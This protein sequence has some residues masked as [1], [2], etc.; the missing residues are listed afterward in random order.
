MLSQLREL[1]F[2]G[3]DAEPSLR[4]LE[5]IGTLH[6]NGATELPHD[7]DVPV[8]AAWR[9]LIN[10]DDRMRALGTASIDNHGAAQGTSLRLSL[11][12]PQPALS[13][14]AEPFLATVD[15]AFEGGPARVGGVARGRLHGY[16]YRRRAALVRNAA[17]PTDGLP[18]RTR[19]LIFGE[20]GAAQFA[21]MII[22]MD[23]RTGIS[24]ILLSRKACDANELVRATLR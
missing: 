20:I 3:R 17:L 24:E 13:G 12:P 7:C 14:T 8:S 10:G 19:D 16:R 4:Q 6:D 5:L 22:E 23:A 21:D 1:G 2:A 18:K 15:G 11:D 9:D